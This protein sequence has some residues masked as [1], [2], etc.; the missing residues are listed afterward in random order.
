MVHSPNKCPP[1]GVSY[2][3]GFAFLIRAFDVV[4]N[5]MLMFK[6]CLTVGHHQVSYIMFPCAATRQ[7][8]SLKHA[9]DVPPL[10]NWGVII[11]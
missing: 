3:A 8:D 4:A 2:V 9:H 6:L 7:F 1:F 11:Q 5:V 10:F